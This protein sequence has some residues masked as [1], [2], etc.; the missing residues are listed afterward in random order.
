MKGKLFKIGNSG[1]TLN[2]R[3][4][5]LNA[6]EGTLIRYLKESDYP[7]KPRLHFLRKKS[8]KLN[9]KQKNIIYYFKK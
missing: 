5:V 6:E 7:L 9:K 1:L 8:N 2:E 3:Y 4:F